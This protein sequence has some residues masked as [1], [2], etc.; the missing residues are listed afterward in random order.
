MSIKFRV[1]VNEALPPAAWYCEVK[2]EEAKVEVGRAVEWSDVHFFEGAWAGEFRDN[3]FLE[4]PCF[5]T[6]ARIEGDTLIFTGPDHVLDRLFVCRG[7]DVLHVSNSLPFLMVRTQRSLS[8][9]RCDYHRI[10]GEIRHG[11]R[12]YRTVIPL[13]D[14][15]S[16][17]AWSWH[18]M[19]VGPN[20]A[21]SPI[22][23]NRHIP[24]PSFS[25]YREFLLRTMESIFANASATERNTRFTPLAT[26]S[27]GYDSLSIAA[28]ARN[29]GCKEAFTFLKSRGK[30]GRSQEDDSGKQA[31]EVLGYRI[32]QLDR[33]AFRKETGFPEIETFGVGS[34][35]A[36]ARH[37]L[38]NR[39]LLTGFMG[40]TMWDREP[41]SVSSD[42]TWP[43]ISG[44]NLTEMRLSAPFIH[45]C[46]PFLACRQHSEIIRISQSDEM[47]PW[48]L[49]TNY[50]RPICRRICEEHGIPRKAFGIK[51]RAA[52]VFFR[53]EGISQTMTPQSY[54][55]YDSYRKERTGVSTSRA[56]ANDRFTMWRL[57]ANSILRKVKAPQWSAE[58]TM[59]SEGALLFQWSLEHL[60]ARYNNV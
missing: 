30:I 48:T 13:C 21:I 11:L 36:S 31:G 43:I 20:L 56:R 10:Y 24:L 1:N 22:E 40:D 6:G 47:A 52:G 8:I 37:L 45:F 34:E 38:A 41:K 14:G 55:N 39:V 28:L 7:Q 54:E 26:I 9:D 25:A 19:K 44:H 2:A 16:I 5:G 51:K 23:K 59:S 18:H 27:S 42:V 35:M 57:A 58:P 29:L 12:N 49:G 15:N 33:L 50:D 60:C 53:E 4:N 3:L 46:V 17:D 32:Y